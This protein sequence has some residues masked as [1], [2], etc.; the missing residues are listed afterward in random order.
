MKLSTDEAMAIA[1]VVVAAAWIEGRVY[2]EQEAAIR[3]FFNRVPDLD[4]SFWRHL[5]TLLERPI[6]PTERI[7]HLRDLRHTVTDEAALRLAQQAVNQVII[8]TGEI[9]DEERAAMKHFSR[10]IR[11]S[12]AEISQEMIR[13][14]RG[15][16]TPPPLVQK[17]AQ[18]A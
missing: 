7:L 4:E 17:P 15:K 1:R 13:L 10:M 8:A 12:E 5:G 9:T 16:D 14:I 18:S 2:A 11:A 6:E 3:D